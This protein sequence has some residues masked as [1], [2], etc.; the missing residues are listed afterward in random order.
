MEC[1]LTFAGF[2]V[3]SCPLK[4]DS[5][6]VVREI[7]DASHHVSIKSQYVGEIINA[8][9]VAISH[10]YSLDCMPFCWY[11][12]NDCWCDY[13]ACLTDLNTNHCTSVCVCV[14]S[15]MAVQEI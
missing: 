3:I 6:S 15:C 8:T 14:Q 2:V 1:D 5:K 9:P 10:R 11:C 7:Q 13:L 4:S 12:Y